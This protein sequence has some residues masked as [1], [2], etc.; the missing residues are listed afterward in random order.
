MLEMAYNR[1]AFTCLELTGLDVKMA[2]GMKEY[3]QHIHDYTCTER[4]KYAVGKAI[5][6]LLE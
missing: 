5:E 6:L 4:V 2:D 3:L 1:D